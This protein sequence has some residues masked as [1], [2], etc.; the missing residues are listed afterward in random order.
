MVGAQGASKEKDS[1]QQYLK[2]SLSKGVLARN[3]TCIS[4]HYAPP[5]MGSSVL[6]VV[7]AW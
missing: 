4:T 3:A 2:D 7:I 6:E 1:K 5:S